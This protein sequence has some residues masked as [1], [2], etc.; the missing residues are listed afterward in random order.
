MAEKRLR[1]TERRLS[2]DESRRT[3]YSQFLQEYQKLRHMSDVTESEN[4]KEGYFMPH[5]AVIKGESLTTKLRVVFDASAKTRTGISLNDALMTGPALQ[6]DLFSLVTR[7]RSHSYVLIFLC[8]K[9]DIEKMFR[10]VRM[11]QED[12]KYQK[13]LWRNN[14]S[15]SIRVYGLQTVTYGTTPGSYLAVRCLHQL[16]FMSRISSHW[17]RRY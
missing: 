5:H 4:A 17:Q 9:A 1:S 11:H 15:E 3:E 6:D 14:P 10:Q 12:V 13:I 2:L 8:T 16:A 7:F